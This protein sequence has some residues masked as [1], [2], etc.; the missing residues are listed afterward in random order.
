MSL[1]LRTWAELIGT[2]VMAAVIAWLLISRA[3]VQTAL[4]NQKVET[5]LAHLRH[6]A[7]SV[8]AASCQ[9]ALGQVQVATSGLVQATQ[10]AYRATEVALQRANT[11]SL[12]VRQEVTRLLSIRPAAGQDCQ[13]A[14]GLARAAWEERQ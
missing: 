1:S 5:K 8:G 7:A 3:N 14:T 12:D 4:A 10:S 13:T 9:A 6:Q 2:A 11:R